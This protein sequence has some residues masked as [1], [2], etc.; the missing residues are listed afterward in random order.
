MSRVEPTVNMWKEMAEEMRA[1]A[2]PIKQKPDVTI[3]VVSFS[4][5]LERFQQ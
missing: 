2:E 4:M 5:P 1:G 3:D